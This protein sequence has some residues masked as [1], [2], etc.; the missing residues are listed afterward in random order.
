[1][2]RISY[3]FGSFHLDL[4]ERVVRRDGNLLPLTPKVF[5]IL[6]VLIQNPGRILTKEEIV[7]QVWPDRIV[8]E[9]NLARNISTLRRKLGEEPDRPQFIE[10][11]PWRGYRFLAE[12]RELHEESE[13]IDSLAVLPFVNEG[14]DPDAEY[15]S[16]GITESLI[17]KLSLLGNLRVMSRNSVF[18][19]KVQNRDENLPDA[20]T[21]GI[22]LGVRAVVTGR[23]RIIDDVVLIGVELVDAGD[24]RHLWGAQYNRELSSIVTLQ[25]TISQQIAGHLKL[26]LTSNDRQRLAKHQT[27]NPEAFQLY[28]KGRHCWNR[29][30]LEGVQKGV[31]FFQQAI[32]KDPAYALAYTGLLDCFS[33]LNQPVEARRAAA[34]ALELDPTLGEVHASLGFFKFLYDW[35]FPGSEEEFK[36]AIELNPNHAQA[37]HGYGT[38]LACMG[39]YEEAIYEAK[40]AC[41]IDPL[42]LQMSQLAGHVLALAHDYGGAIDALLNILEMDPHFVPAHS[43]LVLVYTAKGM[44]EEALAQFERISSLAGGNPIVDANIKAVKALV[45]ASAGQKVEALKII[46]EVSKP[47]EA[48]SYN[49]ARIYAALGEND[50]AFERLDSA[51]RERSPEIVSLKVDPGFD[52]LHSDPR[53]QNLLARVGFAQSQSI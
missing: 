3:K 40:R 29:M 11:I 1:M 23:I 12:V 16:D 10:T 9:S 22:K 42:S 25:E 39:R 19:Y 20:K 30:T 50:H 28:L 4:A 2:E 35:D 15:L 51:Y 37:H 14:N 32:E 36:Q 53:F 38:Y 17:H 43:A 26:K 46:A 13:A 31:E 41:K 49:I 48:T 47:P 8:E 34:K 18:Q 52:N 33:L 44:F 27:E 5:D 6:L 7:K 21:V 45:L 24:N